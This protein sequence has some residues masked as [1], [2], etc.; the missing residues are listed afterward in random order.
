LADIVVGGTE[1]LNLLG[2]VIFG[3]VSEIE[4]LQVFVCVERMADLL[5]GLG[6]VGASNFVENGKATWVVF[7]VL[8]VIVE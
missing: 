1:D 5:K 4:F 3:Q 6:G 8:G 2:V 7:T